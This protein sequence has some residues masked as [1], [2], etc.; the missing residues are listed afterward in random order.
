MPQ[1]HPSV[2]AVPA[3]RDNIIWMIATGPNRYAVVDPGEADP[4][5]AFLNQ[6]AATLSHLLITHHHADHIGGIDILRQRHGG[7]VVGAGHDAH[8]LPRLDQP[9][10]EGAR[11]LLDD[12]RV[13]EVMEVPGHTLG[14][15]AYRVDDALFPGDTLFGFGCGRLFEGTPAMMWHSLSR[16]RALPDTTRLF[17]GHEYT[18]ANL[19]F[20][21]HLEP[22][23]AELHTLKQGFMEMLDGGGFTLPHPLGLEK[24]LN[25]FLR[26]DD[27][28]LAARLGMAGADPVA[29]FALLRERRNRH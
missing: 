22:D 3:A 29:V 17:A 15:L 11:L 4:V 2:E 6:R 9:V 19:D 21:I 26:A 10:S 18:L 27:P 20:V 23:V 25:P 7:R 1:P 5:S 14:H 16:F 24:R 12:N 28:A 8:R 13:A